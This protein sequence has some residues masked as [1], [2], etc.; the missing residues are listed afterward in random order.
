MK[1]YQNRFCC[2]CTLCSHAVLCINGSKG[3]IDRNLWPDSVVGSSR[4]PQ[5]GVC[6]VQC[7]MK[8]NQTSV[9]LM[10]NSTILVLISL[11]LLLKVIVIIALFSGISDPGSA[12]SA[13]TKSEVIPWP[14]MGRGQEGLPLKW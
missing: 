5:I 14:Y 2:L 8:K 7:A 6:C 10:N 4:R 11:L 3:S 1:T 12:L 13:C 9:Q